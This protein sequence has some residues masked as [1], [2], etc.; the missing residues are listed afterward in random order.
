[1]FIYLS[2]Y[3]KLWEIQGNRKYIFRIMKLHDVRIKYRK[4]REYT[5]GKEEKCS[6]AVI[7]R[8]PKIL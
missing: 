1:M 4:V 5:Y 6:M 2:K 3:L 8:M 7:K